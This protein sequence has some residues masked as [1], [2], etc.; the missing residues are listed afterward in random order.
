MSTV[1]AERATRQ[2]S[3]LACVDCDIHPGLS[4][5]GE[6]LPFLSERWRRH[7]Q[8]YGGSQRQGVADTLSH[9]RMMPDTARRDAWPPD[10]TPPGS[11]L[12]FM[13]AQHLDPNEVQ[14]GVL[15]PLRIGAN[16]QRNL[17]FGAALATAMNEWQIAKW[18]SQ[19]KRL[20]GSIVVTQEDPAASIKEIERLADDRRFV[21]V[22]L[23]P[24]AVE[25]MGRARYWPIFECAAANGLPIAMHVGGVNG[26]PVTGAGWP[27][28]YFEEHHANAQ[29]MQGV[30]TSMVF[31]G[32]F[33]RIKRLKLVLIEGGF[34]WSPAHCWR[35][36]KH[37]ARMR[38]EVP[39]LKRPPSEYVRECIW[40]TTQP[41]DEPP[42]PRFLP[43]VMGWVGWD[44]ILFSTDYP[45]W[46]YDAPSFLAEKGLTEA[47]KQM[48]LRDNAKALFGLG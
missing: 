17:E 1:I 7:M 34:I 12:A 35:M 8:T 21:Q 25:P 43:E 45:H 3:E 2:E 44:K 38:D 4:S 22:L 23:P 13:Q 46:D 18:L 30:V 26:H 9:F 42:V 31:E 47:Q 36:D 41:L 14:F 5:P 32:C 11:S 20:R 39:H 19:D 10:G 15:I 33:E 29:M 24:N 48:V 40:Y 37:W 27:S 28:F 6:I 16:N